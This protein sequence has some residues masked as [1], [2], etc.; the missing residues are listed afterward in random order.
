M[1]DRGC[2][3]DVAPYKLSILLSSHLTAFSLFGSFLC[4]SLAKKFPYYP[5][6]LNYSKNPLRFVIQGG[7]PV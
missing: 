1:S 4:T 5:A 6:I 3:S 7:S 2:F